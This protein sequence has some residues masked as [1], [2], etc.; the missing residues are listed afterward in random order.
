MAQVSIQYGLER[1]VS[2][3]DEK[4]IQMILGE[5]TAV[6]DVTLNCSTGIL[7]VDFDNTAFSE[8]ELQHCIAAMNYPIFMIDA[9]MF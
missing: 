8:K 1:Q 7:R 3:W 9:I 2:E 4:R 6:H 5:I